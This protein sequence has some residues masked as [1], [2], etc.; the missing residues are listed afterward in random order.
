M[1]DNYE[2]KPFAIVHK[3]GD[4]QNNC[5]TNLEWISTPILVSE[6]N[7][8]DDGMRSEDEI[9]E[10]EREALDKAWLVRTRP[11]SDPTIEEV[12]KQNVDRILTTYHDIPKDG[13][14]SWQNGYWHGILSA[15]RWVLGE[16]KD[17]L[18]T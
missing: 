17:F 1:T 6:G 10:Y 16:E 8:Y 12:R 11:H 4:W 7:C 14:T 5:A 3:D 13:Y 18:D 9:L 15:L 2:R